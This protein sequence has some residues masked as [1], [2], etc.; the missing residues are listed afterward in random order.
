MIYFVGIDPGTT[1]AYALLNIQ[2][3][4]V[5]LFSERGISP[6][7]LIRKI[8]RVTYQGKVVLLAS[9]KQKSPQT[10]KSIATS[11]GAKLFAPKEDIS[12]AEKN[13]LTKHL[14]TN[15]SHERD[16]AAAILIAFEHYR[17][18]I[19]DIEKYIRKNPEKFKNIPHTLF[20]ESA[21]RNEEQNYTVLVDLLETSLAEHNTS[22]ESSS[23][24]NKSNKNTTQ[25]ITSLTSQSNSQTITSSAKKE[26]K[27]KSAQS[28]LLKNL[29]RSH[30][31]LARQNTH[32]TTQL[33]ILQKKIAESNNPKTT[34][35]K[36]VKEL[37]NLLVQKEK[38]IN[39]LANKIENITRI[40]QSR[41]KA[42]SNLSHAVQTGK[43]IFIPVYNTLSDF[44][45][46]LSKD[47]FKEERLILVNNTRVYDITNVSRIPAKYIILSATKVPEDVIVQSACKYVFYPKKI[48]IYENIAL[49]PV[50]NISSIQKSSMS[51]D[52]RS[53]KE[54]QVLKKVEDVVQ[55]YRNQRAKEL[56]K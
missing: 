52:I 45:K 10:V 7:S 2:T 3:M 20:I 21:I 55:S 43:Y 5:T 6:D 15:N 30:T 40:L 16:A 53:K 32:L 26:A 41:E 36:D 35:T 23:S 34:R 44:I 42:I 24:P 37:M 18:R 54:S 48:A 4:E 49:L 17:L 29:Q 12:V 38:R 13:A 56:R 8:T 28:V 46:S 25:S 11:L 31:N 1:A 39:V 9:D 19:Q 22:Q 14:A 51:P 50:S 47:S 27:G 33:K